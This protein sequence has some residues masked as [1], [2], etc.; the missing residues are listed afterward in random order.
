MFGTNTGEIHHYM[1]K[2]REVIFLFDGI[3]KHWGTPS[4][5]SDEN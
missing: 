1:Q 3:N 5:N 4:D 2:G